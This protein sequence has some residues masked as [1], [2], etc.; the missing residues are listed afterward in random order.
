V[1]RCRRL[2]DV[3]ADP[4]AID[5]ALSVDPLLKRLVR[6]SPGL[7]VPGAV[8]GSELALRAVIGQQISVKGARTIG[9]RLVAG[10]GKPVTVPSGGLTHLF[11]D[12][13]VVADADLSKIGV[14]RAKQATMRLL[15]SA[16]ATGDLTID[17][18][19]DRS[20]TRA[21]LLGLDGI[22][23]WT[24]SYIA[25]RALGDPDAFMAT[26]LGVRRA[27]EQLGEIGNALEVAERWRPW[28]AYAQQHL[29]TTVS[30]QGGER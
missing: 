19:A 3:D 13:D 25:L 24:A 27:L 23:A 17:P 30:Q 1:Q 9:A 18:G 26:D 10:F 20:G 29:W 16:L 8:D 21:E 6:R 2:L 15:A 5:S 14:P 22:G 4:V 28:R 11:P 7:R 12:P